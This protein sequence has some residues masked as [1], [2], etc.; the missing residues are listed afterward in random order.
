MRLIIFLL[1]KAVELISVD[2]TID[3]FLLGQ[4][5]DDRVLETKEND[6]IL[7]FD[8]SEESSGENS[9][10]SSGDG[11]GEGSGEGSG[12]VEHTTNVETTTAKQDPSKARTYTKTKFR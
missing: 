1:A 6:S 9:G 8:Y 7:R 10:E 5:G 4:L 3:V 2:Q 11:S 12:D